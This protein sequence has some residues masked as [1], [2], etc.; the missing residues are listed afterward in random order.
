MPTASPRRP[1]DANPEPASTLVSRNVTVA[2]HR[3]SVRLEPFMW[4]A[5]FEICRR[6]RINQ[7]QLCTMIA[8]R[9]E[10]G[11]SLTSAIR[12][13]LV[14]YNRAAATEE[15]HMWARHGGGQPFV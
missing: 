3:T 14:A 15:G 7:H 4:S 2:G 11:T 9:K 6:E 8:E 10:A 13:F 1:D 5:L 12:V